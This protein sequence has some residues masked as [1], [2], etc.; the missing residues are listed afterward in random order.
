MS[1]SLTVRTAGRST[2][3]VSQPD[4]VWRRTWTRAVRDLERL[5]PG[6]AGKIE[7]IGDPHPDLVAGTVRRLVAEQQEV[8]SAAGRALRLDRL[9]DRGGGGDRI[10]LTVLRL[11]Q[12]AALDAERH[13]VA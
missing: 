13:G 11:E 12:D 4:S 8:V 5:D 2:V 1:P 6:D 3:A 10:P 7:S 9:D